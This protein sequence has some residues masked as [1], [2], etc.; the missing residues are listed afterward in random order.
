MTLN[1]AYKRH[2]VNPEPTSDPRTASSSSALAGSSLPLGDG[3]DRALAG[4]VHRD[5][6]G[7][8]KSLHRF[9]VHFWRQLC[10]SLGEHWIAV[11][12]VSW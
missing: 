2:M 3:D 4:C 12:T 7:P 10:V 11:P 9:R 1:V 5:I 6:P 8:H